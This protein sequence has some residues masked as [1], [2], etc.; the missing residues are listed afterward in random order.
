MNPSVL[1]FI[2]PR[3]LC[4]KRQGLVTKGKK[5]F[6]TLWIYSVSESEMIAA[7]YSVENTHR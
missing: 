6:N 3:V 5:V 2:F 7:N 4:S 1:G